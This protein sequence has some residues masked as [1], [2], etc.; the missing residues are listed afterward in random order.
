MKRGPYRNRSGMLESAL[1]YRR[2]G[3]SYCMISNILQV[4]IGTIRNWVV[5]VPSDKRAAEAI[6]RSIRY[7]D[8]KFSDLSTM[9]SRKNFLIGK[10]GRICETCNG[11][12]WLGSPISIEL[13]HR[14]GNKRNNVEE[15]LQLLCPN[16]HSFTEH[17]RGRNTS[18]WRERNLPV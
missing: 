13:H 18:K 10:R 7:K 14:D 4:P 15:N 12:E 9:Q 3:L 6:A 17:Y 2:N 8:R 11:A 16:C 5:G 1:S